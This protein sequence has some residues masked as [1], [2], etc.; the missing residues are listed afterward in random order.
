GPEPAGQAPAASS[1]TAEPS[2]SSVPP[3]SPS[4]PSPEGTPPLSRPARVA[5]VIDDLGRSTDD[6]IP[7]ERLGVTIT[8]AVLPF[9]EN[10][11]A[12]V[13][14]LRSRRKEILLHLPM[15]PKHGE[16]PGPGA[17]RLGMTDGELRTRT[18]AAPQ[19]VPGAVRVN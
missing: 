17:L 1:G 2:A 12:V 3:S 10:T 11:P 6:L 9:E 14:Q 7:L 4:S 18:L 5:L 16:N 8:Y 15:Q 19:A 13:E